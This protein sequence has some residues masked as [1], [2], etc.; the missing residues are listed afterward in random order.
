M[1]G[2]LWL[3]RLYFRVVI[4][5]WLPVS[6]SAVDLPNLTFRTITI[7]DGL[8]NNIINTIYKDKRGFIWLG[9]QTGLDR[10]DGI[11]MKSFLQFSGRTI[12]SIA[13]TDSVYLWVGTDK[14]LWKLDRKTD[15]VE[16]VTLDTKSLEVRSVFGSPDKS[17]GKFFN[18][19]ENLHLCTMNNQGLLALAQLILPSEILS[20]FEV[21]RV[22]EEAS[23][24]RIYLDESV[25]AEY[26]ENPEIESKG[27]CEA[28][29]IRDFPIR[30]KGVDLIVR[31]R[32]W[33]DKQ[34]NRYFS[35]SYDLKAEETR[36]SK[37]FAAFLKGVYGDDSYDLPFA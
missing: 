26:K 17:G 33:Y 13:E 23:L 7:S 24:I 14:G 1:E 19:I 37:E 35:D 3:Y 36:Y 27:F 34:N 6:L 12:F 25:K 2:N 9:T 18:S 21:V 15:Q 8:S 30:D 4:L 11:N 5:L 22:E 16:S 32:K 28:V 20:N 31:R 29:T 10:F